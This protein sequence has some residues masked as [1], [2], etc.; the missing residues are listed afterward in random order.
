MALYEGWTAEFPNCILDAAYTLATCREHLPYKS[1]MVVKDGQVILKSDQV[2]AKEAPPEVAMIFT[3]QGSQ[4][5]GMGRELLKDVNFRYDLECMDTILA[6]LRYPPKWRILG[7]LPCL[8]CAE[9]APTTIHLEKLLTR[10]HACPLEELEKPSQDSRVD[11]AYLAQPLC[12]ALQIALVHHFQRLGVRPAAV[13]GH[14]SGEIAAAYAAGCITLD[15]ALAAAYYRGYVTLSGRKD[16]AMASI[17]LG[18]DECG[19]FLS[20]DVVVACENS[21][22]STTISGEQRAV[23]DAVLAINEHQEEVFT[24]LLKVEMAYHSGQY[25]FSLQLPWCP[26]PFPTPPRTLHPSKPR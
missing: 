1:F 21:P 23:Q 13:V 3:G 12:T 26:P 18:A 15:F 24:R 2:K 20:G 11:E 10:R 4:W 25:I 17:G 5:A 8:N 22:Q 9:R 14:S 16:G 19:Q 6:G 7:E